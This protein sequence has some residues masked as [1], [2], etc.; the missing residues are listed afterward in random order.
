LLNGNC[1]I[2]TPKNP[3]TGLNKGLLGAVFYLQAAVFGKGYDDFGLIRPVGQDLGGF[4]H[5]KR[6]GFYFIQ[7][8]PTIYPQIIVWRIIYLLC[9]RKRR[10]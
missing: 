4:K 2:G 3:I 8:Y 5:D 10:L 7:E 6:S 9:S 1:G